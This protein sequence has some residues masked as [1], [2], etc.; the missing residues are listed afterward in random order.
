[1]VLDES[2]AAALDQQSGE[3]PPS[4]RTAGRDY[5]ARDGIDGHLRG[6]GLPAG[7]SIGFG[8]SGGAS[9]F[10]Y[11][12]KADAAERVRL[13]KAGAGEGR[14]TG[15][16]GKVRECNVCGT[17]AINSGATE[18]TCGHHD[19]RWVDN[20]RPEYVAHP[21]VKPLALMR[22]LVRLVT[23]PGGVV[24]EPFAGS[25]A[26][27]EACI[28]EGFKCV[29]IEREADYLPLILQR[30][31]RRRDPVAAVLAASEDRGLFDLLDD[32]QGA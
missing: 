11:T 30:I 27:V 31:H 14:V 4:S 9:R 10:F 23:P 7:K 26:T 6:V 32:E 25:G 24:L 19:H 5:T 18:L 3:A 1:V 15:L 29:A 2:Q 16:G 20:P 13:P 12:A 21:T 17:R 8:D 28:L 22:W